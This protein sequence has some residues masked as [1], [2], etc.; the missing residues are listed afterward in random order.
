VFVTYQTL[1]ASV[2]FSGSCHRARLG[3]TDCCNA[4]EPRCFPCF[5]GLGK[6]LTPQDALSAA[7]AGCCNEVVLLVT[8]SGGRIFPG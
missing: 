7:P 3:S 2:D 1:E 5:E 8:R 4:A 6:P